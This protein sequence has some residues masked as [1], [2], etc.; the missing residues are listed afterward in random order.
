[1][2]LDLTPYEIADAFPQEVR[3]YCPSII[4][5]LELSM[6]K[7]R[8]LMRRLELFNQ[9][10]F[11]GKVYKVEGFYMETLAK[12]YI[13]LFYYSNGQDWINKYKRCLD[14]I[15]SKNTD[16]IEDQ[17]AIQWAKAQ[18]IETMFSFEKPRRTGK[19]LMA[20]CPFHTE[21]SP[22]FVVYRDQNKFHCFGCSVQGDA[23]DFF[24]KINKVSFKQAIQSM[25]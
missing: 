19:R 7:Y 1:M 16:M 6:L 18:P 3:E 13:T 12:C 5:K 25:Q 2:K 14:L 17:A 15:K 24:M 11:E 23:I 20:I 9:L 22:S 8:S 21:K 4:Q 10:D